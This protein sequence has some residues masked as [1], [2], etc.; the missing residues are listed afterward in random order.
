[1]PLLYTVSAGFLRVEEMETNGSNPVDVW[2]RESGELTLLFPHNGSFL[3]L[4]PTAGEVS[5][6][7]T[8]GPRLPAGIGMQN[9]PEPAPAAGIGPTN[10]PG[11]P[12]LP[13]MPRP[14]GMPPRG[15]LPVSATSAGPGAMPMGPH[16]EETLELTPTG[17]RTNLLGFA[18]EQFT[19]KERDHTMEIWA[20]AA[21][22]PFQD[23]VRRQQPRFGH[24][25][26]EERW[27][28]MLKEKKL[29]PLL[30]VMRHQHGEEIFRFEVNTI[31][32]EKVSYEKSLFEPPPGYQEIQPLPF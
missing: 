30:A 7:L 6:P 18:C 24:R 12:T 29:F 23:Y 15:S 21:L 9:H 2:N 26:L 32:A 25:M 10:L 19:L 31:T 14:P 17:V 28:E 8:T 16:G 5:V 22:M 3:R 11:A 20:T 1:L 27:G 4:K 13:A